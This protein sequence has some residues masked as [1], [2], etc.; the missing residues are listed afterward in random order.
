MPFGKEI[1]DL[2]HFERAFERDREVELP[3]EEEHAVCIGI[4]FRDRFDLIAQFQNRLDLA[5]QRFQRFDHAASFGG[6]K[7]SHPSEEQA[8]QRENSKLAT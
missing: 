1:G 6:G 4:F 5:G 8:E 3:A 7:V 2:L